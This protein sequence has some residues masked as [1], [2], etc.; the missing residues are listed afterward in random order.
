MGLFL[1]PSETIVSYEDADRSAGNSTRMWRV[2]EVLTF[3]PSRQ[4][5]FRIS[6]QIARWKFIGRNFSDVQDSSGL[7][8]SI[9]WLPLIWCKFG[10]V[11]SYFDVSGASADTVEAGFSAIFEASYR[12]WN[13]NLTYSYENEEDKIVDETRQIHKFVVN[14]I[15][16]QF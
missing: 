3:K 1:G 13:G 8:F 11:G 9:D 6:G 10:L 4:L 2:E 14:I 12:I 5:F 7:G 15:R 16:I